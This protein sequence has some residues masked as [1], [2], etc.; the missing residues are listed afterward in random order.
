MEAGLLLRLHGQLCRA[1]RQ[2]SSWQR[3]FVLRELGMGMALARL[4]FRNKPLL[5]RA[6]SK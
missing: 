3:D 6:S 1:S 5:L 2:S 4:L